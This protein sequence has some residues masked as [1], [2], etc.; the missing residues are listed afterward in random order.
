MLLAPAAQTLLYKLMRIWR[1]VFLTDVEKM[2][3]KPPITEERIK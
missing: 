2:K 1:A 3:R